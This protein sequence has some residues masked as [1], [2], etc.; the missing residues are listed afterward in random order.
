MLRIGER[1]SVQIG[2]ITAIGYISNVGYYGHQIELTK[3][4]RIIG[5]EIEWNRPTKGS[6]EAHRL[7][8]VGTLLDEWQDKSALVDLALL[9]KDKRF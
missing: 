8:P 4:A 5:G 9:T 6:Y 3:V 7:E 2:D 1:V